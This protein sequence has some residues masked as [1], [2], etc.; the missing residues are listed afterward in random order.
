MHYILKAARRF[1]Q[2][3]AKFATSELIVKIWQLDD[4]FNCFAMYLEQ[5]SANFYFRSI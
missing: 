4:V 5:Q 2:L 1:E 3:V